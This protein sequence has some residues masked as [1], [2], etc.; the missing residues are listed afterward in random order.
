M[1][2]P[3]LRGNQFELEAVMALSYKAKVY[4][5]GKV[6]PIIEPVSATKHCLAKYRKLVSLQ[7]PFVL[8][9]NP[10]VGN[11]R[12]EV[13]NVL[14]N[15][16]LQ[17]YD[18]YNLGYIISR[19]TEVDDLKQFIDANPDRKISLI[20]YTL[21]S[22]SAEIITYINSLSVIEHNIIL[23]DNFKAAYISSIS[24]SHAKKIILADGFK[25][26]I[27]NAAYA[28]NTTEFFSNQH[29][30]FAKNGY[31]GFG[32]F[33]TIGEPYASG[34]GIP[35]AVVIHWT[36]LLADCAMVNHFVSDDVS[37]NKNIGGKFG[38]AYEKLDQF[39]SEEETAKGTL[40][41]E[42]LETQYGKPGKVPQLGRIK[43]LSIMHHIEL[44]R[45]TLS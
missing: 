31:E 10:L 36:H 5:Q 32:D 14:I 15:G 33:C 6:L 38:Q 3:Y 2:T 7:T 13:N 21:G 41:C 25:K 40:G 17:G 29:L 8:I 20:H 1:Y 4:S 18:G 35:H 30:E 11:L 26:A 16:T 37:D 43:Q 45:S 19:L 42:M 44:M 9:V 28:A 27:N 22:F 23:A 24:D 34:K 12:G 39:W